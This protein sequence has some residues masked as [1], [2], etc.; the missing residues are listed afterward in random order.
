MVESKVNFQPGTT[1]M[2]TVYS[3]DRGTR[4]A[5]IGAAVFILSPP[6]QKKKRKGLAR[7]HAL[8]GL[9]LP[10]I[11]YLRPPV[12]SAV[13]VITRFQSIPDLFR[14]VSIN[15]HNQHRYVCSLKFRAL[16]FVDT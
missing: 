7:K 9:P 5:Y 14:S 15:K 3:T 13:L 6:A 1:E 12:P 10:I 16:I 4:V 2:I 11:C 8:A